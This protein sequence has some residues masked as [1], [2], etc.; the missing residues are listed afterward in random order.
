VSFLLDESV[1][2]R[3]RPVVNALRGLPAIRK[4]VEEEAEGHILLNAYTAV[5]GTVLDFDRT[6]V[7]RFPTWD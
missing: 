3:Y 1:A 4:Q 7:G 5:I 6:P 2:K